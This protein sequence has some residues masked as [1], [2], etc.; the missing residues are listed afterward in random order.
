[1]TSPPRFEEDSLGKVE[2]PANA[3]Y[4]ARTA[5]CL[6]NMSFSGKRLADF[7]VMIEALALVKKAAAIANHRSGVLDLTRRD[8]IAEACDQ[9][10]SGLHRE[11]F[12]ADMFAGGGSIAINVNVNEVIANL[13]NM[14][15][16]HPCG[17]YDPVHPKLHVNASQST[18]DVCHSAQNLAILMHWEAL[19][20]ALGRLLAASWEKAVEFRDVSVIA[21][22]CMQDAMA[23]LLGDSFSAIG[24]MIGRRKHELGA[25]IFCLRSLNLGGTVIG[26]GEGA[27]ESYR[28]SI[29]EHLRHVSGRDVSLAENL[30]DAAQNIDSLAAVSANLSLLGGSLIKMCKDLRLMASA[31]FGEI[32]LPAVQEGSSFFKGKVNPVVPETLIQ[33]CF[34]VEGADRSVKASLEHGELNLNV[35]EGAAGALVLDSI[36]MLARCLDLFVDRCFSGIT[37]NRHRSSLYEETLARLRAPVS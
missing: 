13:A 3:L 21:R 12:V 17:S 37:A 27:S 14:S 33:C 9:L 20:A 2:L 26:S 29:I 18:A 15:V 11:Q 36:G 25:A 30:F 1:M 8:L 35:F 28:L 19:D 7:P 22:T 6:S 10:R 23:T 5:R 32:T 16:G 24:A 34:L 31:G 4:G